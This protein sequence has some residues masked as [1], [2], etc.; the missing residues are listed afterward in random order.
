MK[1]ADISD[2]LSDGSLLILSKHAIEI[3]YTESKVVLSQKK[4][5]MLPDKISK[6][7]LPLLTFSTF[8]FILSSGCRILCLL[9]SLLLSSTFSKTIKLGKSKIKYKADVLERIYVS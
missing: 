6:G 1:E 3:I 2:P 9:N 4:V 7:Y 5:S 8:L